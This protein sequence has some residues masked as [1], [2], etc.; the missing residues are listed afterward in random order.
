MCTCKN[1]LQEGQSV[2]GASACPWNGDSMYLHPSLTLPTPAPAACRRSCCLVVLVVFDDLGCK[3]LCEE[4][5]I[6][7]DRGER[8][9]AGVGVAIDSVLPALDAG[10][11]FICWCLAVT[12]VL[13]VVHGLA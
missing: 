12:R 1:I 7:A 11:A 3:S 9:A 6:T 2:V 10:V 13:I 5:D 4:S 8:L